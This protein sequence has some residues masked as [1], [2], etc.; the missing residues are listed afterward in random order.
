MELNCLLLDKNFSGN[1]MSLIKTNMYYDAFLVKK[2]Y[3]MH[4][5]YKRKQEN[6][7]NN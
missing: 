7:T 4:H 2:S 5:S 1:I 6:Y 3:D